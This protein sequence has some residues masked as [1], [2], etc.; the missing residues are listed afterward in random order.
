MRSTGPAQVGKHEKRVL[1]T[2]RHDEPL[3]LR[4]GQ[5]TVKDLCPG[6]KARIQ[7]DPNGLLSASVMANVSYGL[8]EVPS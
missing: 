2:D 3:R 4:S 8:R 6:E 7:G 1:S 5:A